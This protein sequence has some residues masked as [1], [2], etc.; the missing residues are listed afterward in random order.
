MKELSVVIVTYN[1]EPDIYGCLEALFV[2]ND[3]GNALEVIV[4]DNNS[5]NFQYMKAEIA[6]LYG[7]TVTV[8]SNSQN[9]G[10]GQG[11]NIGIRQ[12]SS[13]IVMVMNPDVRL[14]R[15]SL[16]ELVEEYKND[17]KIAICGFKQVINQ[18]GKRGVSFSMLNHYSG[19]VRLLGGIV[20]KRLD[21]FCWRHMYF[22][23]A[24]FCVRKS[25][26]EEAGL[27]DENIFLYGEE[28]DI[29]YRIHHAFPEAHDVYKKEYV[30]LHPTEDRPYSET[31]FRRRI[32]SN[33][34]VM[35][36]QG[37]PKGTYI[38]SEEERT[39]WTKRLIPNAK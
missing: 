3:I 13:P 18:S 1:S 25:M 29:H 26:F 15:I 16:K 19:L 27:F 10:Y 36:K 6:R 30:Y 32:A 39:K 8:L 24:C 34:Y 23:G 37:R 12:A 14:V 35:Q 2:H 7:E 5:R 31:A 20:A 28:N 17:A 21:W 22:C 11:N 9:G 33:E 38:R 4:V